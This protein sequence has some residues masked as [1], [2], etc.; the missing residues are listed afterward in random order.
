MTQIS[1]PLYGSRIGINNNI[2]TGNFVILSNAVV[3]NPSGEQVSIVSTSSSDSSSGAGIQKVRLRY[4]DTN[5]I[6][7]DEIITMNGTTPVLSVATNIFRIEAF[8]AFRIGNGFIGAVG[9]ITAKNISGTNL[10]AQIDPTYNNFTRTLHFVSPNKRGYISDVTLN[11]A[12]SG[13]IIFA[14]FI[15]A[16][17]TQQGGNIILIPDTAISLTNGAI[18][19]SFPNPIMCDASQSTQGLM[20]G[21]AAKG[22]AAGQTGIASFHYAETF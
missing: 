7:N 1:I 21:V 16:D 10:Y 19:M 2:G 17:N 8:E 5:W 6:L 13:G 18:N 4:F 15:S 9:T 14:I 22:L 12:T 3:V 11:C 20:M